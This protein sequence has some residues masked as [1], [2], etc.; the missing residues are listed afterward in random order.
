MAEYDSTPVSL[1]TILHPSENWEG[2]PLKAVVPHQKTETQCPIYWNYAL[3]RCCFG[4][5]Y[6]LE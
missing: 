4:F 5:L 6:Q 3:L 1:S 2:A